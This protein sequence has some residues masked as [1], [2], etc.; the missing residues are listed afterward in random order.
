MLEAAKSPAFDWVFR[1]YNALWL[2]ARH[3]HSFS[4]A[5]EL[6]PAGPDSEGKP[7]LYMMNHSSWWDG[8]LAYH[9]FSK[10]GDG[11][12]YCM[13][14]ER[15]LQK[16]RFFRKLGAYSIDRS[17]TPDIMASLRYSARLLKEGG[18]VWMYPQGEIMPLPSRPLELQPGISLVLR[19]CPEAAVVPVTLYHGLFGHSRPEASLLAG[20]PLSLPWKALKREEVVAR[21]GAAL[22]GQLQAHES[23][24]LEAKGGLPPSFRPLIRKGRS[25]N[26]WFDLA[27]GAERL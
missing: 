22:N 4:I 5:G 12:F 17:R 21:L 14:E 27:R 6:S 25:V 24:V 16:Y 26:E 13:M 10:E 18:R 20:K 15:Q 9:A 7:L 23:M 19:L 11:D 2:L 8:L 1:R 3:F